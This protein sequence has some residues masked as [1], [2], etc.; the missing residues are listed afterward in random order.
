LGGLFADG[1]RRTDCFNFAG[2]GTT[3]FSVGLFRGHIL[4]GLAP[5]YFWVDCLPMV[6]DGLTVSILAGPGTT[7]FSVGLFRGVNSYFG[8]L[9]PLGGLAPVL[10][11][12]EL[13]LQIF[14]RIISRSK[15]IFWG[16][17]TTIFLGGLFADER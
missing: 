17:G 8:G 16:T 14:G 11:L 6:G 3:K 2:T 15:L 13:A 7:K 10:I 5:Q 9:A 12:R 4:G 1:W